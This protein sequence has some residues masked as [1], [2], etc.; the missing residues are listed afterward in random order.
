MKTCTDCNEAL[1][2]SNF[3]KKQR[4]KDGLDIR[5][6]DCRNTRYNK[7]DPRRVFAKIYNSQVTHSV[8]RG[9]PAPAYTLD[10]LKTWVDEQP[11][12]HHLWETYVAS[13]YDRGSKPSVDRIDD[14]KPYTLDNILLT[15]WKKNHQKGADSK[16]TGDIQVGHKPV[17]AYSKDGKLHRKYGSINEA[18]RDVGGSMWGITSVANGEP[19]KDGRGK[20]Y[21]PRSYKGF[22]WKWT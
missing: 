14:S 22:V 10:E 19:V 20:L 16:R 15:S 1:P 21:T 9:H 7:A 3:H 8:T 4:N 18:L 17:A 5:C 11:N 12:A 6:K 2:L 13:G